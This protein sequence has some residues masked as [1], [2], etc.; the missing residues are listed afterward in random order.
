MCGAYELDIELLYFFFRGVF[1]IS[2]G[3]EVMAEE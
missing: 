2:E 3:E 1:G